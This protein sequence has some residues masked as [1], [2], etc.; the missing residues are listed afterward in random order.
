MCAVALAGEEDVKTSRAAIAVVLTLSAAGLASAA[1][2]TATVSGVVQG[3]SAADRSFSVRT[4]AGDT[5][6][7][8]WT[9]ETKF[10]GVVANGSRVT[11]RFTPQPGGA[12]IAQT[13]G[14]LK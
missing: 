6:A 14:V 1:E 5:V 8:V 2:K 7:L 9:K 4:D 12:N 10:N 11:V 13:V 3:Y